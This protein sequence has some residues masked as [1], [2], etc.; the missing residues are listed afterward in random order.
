MA[1]AIWDDRLMSRAWALELV[2]SWPLVAAPHPGEQSLHFHCQVAR[3]G[4]AGDRACFQSVARMLPGYRVTIE[5]LLAGVLRHAVTAH[6]LD[7]G[8]RGRKPDGAG[9]EPRHLRR[10]AG[11]GGTRP[12]DPRFRN[13][14]RDPEGGEEPPG[15][16]AA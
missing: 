6:E 1:E 9:P 8:Q 5:E 12:I 15:G 13:E 16:D 14:R 10:V 2:G 3:H 11:G 4:G 7:T